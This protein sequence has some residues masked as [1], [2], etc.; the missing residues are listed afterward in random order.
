[1][2]KHLQLILLSC[3]ALGVSGCAS[4]GTYFANRGR[5]AVDIFTLTVDRGLG[6]AAQ[7]GPLSTGVG[8]IGDG[9]GLNCG[10]VGKFTDC[11]DIHFLVLG[12]N[13]FK[14]PKGSGRNKTRGHLQFLCIKSTSA[15]FSGSHR[16]NPFKDLL[17][18]L[19]PGTW[20]EDPGVTQFELSAAL[21]IG[22]RAG[23]NLMELIDFIVGWSTLD[24]L[25]D[26]KAPAKK[27]IEIEQ[28][29]GETTSTTAPSAVPEASHP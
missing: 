15:S 11:G 24:V 7:A 27:E 6:V 20:I 3:L 29:D 12:W 16:V 22:P 14:S 1:M 13:E 25:G 18:D 23:F 9:V 21:G 26:D 28:S 8:F 5:D 2:R 17:V 4:T 19:F 10:G